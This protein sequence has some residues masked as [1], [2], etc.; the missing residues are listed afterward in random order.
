MMKKGLILVLATT[1]GCGTSAVPM[2]ASKSVS[3]KLIAEGKPVG[4]VLLTFQ[5]LEDGHM[6][7]VEVK[8]D[9][10]F[11]SELVPGKYAYFIGKSARKGFE[12][13]VKQVSS[14]FYEADLSRTVVLPSADELIISLE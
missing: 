2:A 12:S 4:N 6:T 9:G 10:T 14:K 11:E 5:P 8:A 1:L 7:P 13:A 3:G